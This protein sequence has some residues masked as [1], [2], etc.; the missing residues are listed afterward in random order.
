MQYSYDLS[1]RPASVILILHWTAL[2]MQRY[3]E[4][5]CKSRIVLKI[6]LTV[7]FVKWTYD[8]NSGVGSPNFLWHFSGKSNAICKASC[9]DNGISVS[10][11]YLELLLTGVL[12]IFY[13]PTVVFFLYSKWNNRKYHTICIALIMHLGHKTIMFWINVQ[14]YTYHYQPHK[15]VMRKIHKCPIVILFYYKQPTRC[16]LKQSLFT[17]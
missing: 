12:N 16:S 11:E 7:L 6:T 17:A 4:I 8:Y 10:T 3:I 1:N 13:F 9:K 5:I 14:E 15:S 2:F